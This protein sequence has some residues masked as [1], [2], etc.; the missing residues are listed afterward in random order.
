MAEARGR[1]GIDCDLGDFAVRHFVGA[2]ELE[3][4]RS[5]LDL[6]AVGQCRRDQRC[7]DF[8]VDLLDFSAEQILNQREDWTGVA[9]QQSADGGKFPLD[10]IL[11]PTQRSFHVVF[12][13]EAAY[14]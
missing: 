4:G 8:L 3:R 7:S 6:E 1:M 2:P 14:R 13:S 9:L 11:S 12:V 5:R 10:V